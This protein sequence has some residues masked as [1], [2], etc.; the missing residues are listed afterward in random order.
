MGSFPGA[1]KELGAE[2]RLP[3]PLT[4]VGPR[5]APSNGAPPE[6]PFAGGVVSAPAAQAR[7]ELRRNRHAALRRPSKALGRAASPRA[8]RLQYR[9][10]LGSLSRRYQHP[11]PA[12]R[13]NGIRCCPSQK[14]TVRLPVDYRVSDNRAKRKTNYNE[15]RKFQSIHPK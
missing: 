7:G 13:T 6:P 10:A 1:R 5:S 4:L 14:E 11:V 12:Q 8:A 15:N 2:T 9:T 3:S